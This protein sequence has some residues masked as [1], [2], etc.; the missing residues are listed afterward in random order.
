M[1]YAL[2][3]TAYTKPV[4]VAK[5]YGWTDNPKKALTWQEPSAKA[6]ESYCRIMKTDFHFTPVNNIK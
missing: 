5:D 6:L 2:V 3:T 4:F 1:H